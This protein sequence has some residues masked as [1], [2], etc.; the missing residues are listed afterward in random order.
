[1]GVAIL[2]LLSCPPENCHFM[3]YNK[4]YYMFLH[5]TLLNYYDLV[6]TSRYHIIRPFY[7]LCLNSRWNKQQ[8]PRKQNLNHNSTLSNGRVICHLDG[9]MQKFSRRESQSSILQTSRTTQKRSAMNIAIESYACSIIAKI[10]WPT[11]ICQRFLPP[12]LLVIL[13]TAT[14]HIDEFWLKSVRWKLFV[15]FISHLWTQIVC[16]NPDSHS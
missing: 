16:R 12:M 13:W 8:S 4:I 7:P 5:M 3:S 9:K 15:R 11:T 10:P 1:M 6:C 14:L 2:P